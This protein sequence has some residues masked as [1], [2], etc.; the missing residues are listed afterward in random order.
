MC[1]HKR[2]GYKNATFKIFYT[3]ILIKKSV[4]WTICRS[5]KLK[6]QAYCLYVD[7]VCGENMWIAGS[8]YI[9]F[10]TNKLG[11]LSGT[12]SLIEIEMCLSSPKFGGYAIHKTKLILHVVSAILLMCRPT[13]VIERH[14][15]KRESFS[16][17][18]LNLDHISYWLKGS[19]SSTIFPIG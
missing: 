9:I 5:K 3:L 17:S 19:T 1:F 11:Y 16:P 6:M 18:R 2:V 13:K 15:L 4:R 8:N 14:P 10:I 7:F 12:Q